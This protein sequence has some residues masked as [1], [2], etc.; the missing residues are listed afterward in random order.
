MNPYEATNTD[1]VCFYA[2]S[3]GIDLI[4]S[5]GK[6]LE[7]NENNSIIITKLNTTS[8]IAYMISVKLDQTTI[9]KIT[10][11]T[12]TQAGVLYVVPADWFNKTQT[13]ID[14]IDVFQRNNVVKVN[15]S[16]QNGTYQNPYVL[17]TYEDVVAIGSSTVNKEAHYIV[18][19]MIDMT[20]VTA[21]PLADT[22]KG[23]IRGVSEKAG[24]TNINITKYDGMF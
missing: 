8:S 14:G 17:S 3:S 19:D 9:N 5:D 11:L 12:D 6:N 23:S 24:F 16:F 10:N 13:G 1:I 4:L 21:Y 2:R 15:I 18:Y 22:F 7:H 20:K